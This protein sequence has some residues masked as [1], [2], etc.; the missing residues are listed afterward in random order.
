MTHNLRGHRRYRSWSGTATNDP[1]AAKPRTVTQ[2]GIQRHPHRQPASQRPLTARHEAILR[3]VGRAEMASAAH[4]ARTL[5][6]P[7]S[8]VTATLYALQARGLV[9]RQPFHGWIRTI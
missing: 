3:L 8:G 9:E 7:P 2:A 6:L 1:K 4:I 5:G